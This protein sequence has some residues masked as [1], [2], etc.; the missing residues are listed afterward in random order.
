MM[1]S[2][3]RLFAPALLT[4]Y[5]LAGSTAHAQAPNV[6]L[7][8]VQ[9]IYVLPMGSGMDQFVAHQLAR[10]GLYEVTTDPRQ[11]DAFLSDFVGTTFET[12]VDD[13]LKA[14]RD[15]A[16][17]EAEELARKEAAKAP[18]PKESDKDSKDK[19]EETDDSRSG[20][21]QMAGDAARVHSF[22][23]GRG[24]IFLVDAKTRRVLWTGFD[25]PKN[26][27]PGELQKSAE[28]LVGKLRKEKTGK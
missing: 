22:S 3:V 24:N 27:R 23:R 12:R 21:F 25:V 4:G 5:L 15:K 14:A 26:T 9:V 8:S 16:E 28:R 18:K 13:L 20:E 1:I 11:A 7:S 2:M 17:K 19:K 6:E 10:H